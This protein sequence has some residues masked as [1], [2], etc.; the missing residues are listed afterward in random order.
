MLGAKLC[1]ICGSSS[2]YG[3]SLRK[4]SRFPKMGGNGEDHVTADKDNDFSKRLIRLMEERDLTIRQLAEKSGTSPSNVAN[5]REGFKA[6]DYH[7]LKRLSTTLGVSLSFLLTGEEDSPIRGVP[8]MTEVFDDGG[9][10]F[11]G[12]LEVKIKRM[13]PKSKV[14]K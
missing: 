2:I 1:V 10:V 8:S 5:W 13:I 4:S 3:I 7:A 14:K 11:D 9:D 12:F 6:T